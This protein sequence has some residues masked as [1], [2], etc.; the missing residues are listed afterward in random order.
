MSYITLCGEGT[1]LRFL[2]MH[3]PDKIIGL[4]GERV[5][6][7]GGGGGVRVVFKKGISTFKYLHVCKWKLHI[8]CILQSGLDKMSHR[9]ETSYSVYMYIAIMLRQNES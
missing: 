9:V 2:D 8:S 6:E 7:V 4:G 3:L 5:Y 1:Y